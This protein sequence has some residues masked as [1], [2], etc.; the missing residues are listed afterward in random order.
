M[1]IQRGP[2]EHLVYS[3]VDDISKRM[4]QCWRGILPGAVIFIFFSAK[5]ACFERFAGAAAARLSKQTRCALWPSARPFTQHVAHV[6]SH[7]ALQWPGGL[8]VV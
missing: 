5:L 7:S 6:P 2:C 3:A 4:E 1:P 8:V